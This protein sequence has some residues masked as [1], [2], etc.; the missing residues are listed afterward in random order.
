LAPEDRPVLL[1]HVDAEA[2]C[3]AGVDDEFPPLVVPIVDVEVVRKAISLVLILIDLLKISLEAVAPA[4]FNRF[5][6]QQ[7]SQ[8]Q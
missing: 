1:A 3:D 7:R 4:N 5:I 6:E 8:T 2:N